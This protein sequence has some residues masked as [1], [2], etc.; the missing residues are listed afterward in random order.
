MNKISMFK[1]SIIAV[2][3]A[4]ASTAALATDV[5]V[6]IS[7]GQPGFYGRIDIGEYPYPQPRVIYRRPI[8]VHRH[9]DEYEPIYLRVPPGHAR[10]WSR[11][12][13][14]YDACDRP[15]YFVQERW[16]RDDYV[17]YYREYH[18][19]GYD[20]RDRGYDDRDRGYEDHDRGRGRE[21]DDHGNGHKGGNGKNKGNRGRN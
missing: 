12:C 3:L 2:T 18:G 8:I 5:G 11:Y 6:S 13:G 17:P 15:V 4:L 20:D 21:D 7:V 10:Q 19:R 9:Y 14:R 1:R 16:Y